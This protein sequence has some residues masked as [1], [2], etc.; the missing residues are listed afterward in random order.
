MTNPFQHMASQKRLKLAVRI[1]NVA[2]C[3]GLLAFAL[4]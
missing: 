3:L 4:R 1:L 2:L